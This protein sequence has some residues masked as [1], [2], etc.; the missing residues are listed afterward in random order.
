MPFYFGLIKGSKTLRN[1][2]TAATL[3]V[4]TDEENLAAPFAFSTK[5]LAISFPNGETLKFPDITVNFGEKILLSGD[6]GAGKSTL[7]KLLLGILLP[8]SGKI[9]FKDQE[10]KVI[11]PDLAKIGYIAQDP[12]LFPSTIKNNITMFDSKL[13]QLAE[14]AAV[15]VG[16]KPDLAQFAQGIET[17]L[18]LQKLNVS[19]GQRQKIIL[20]RTQIHDSK[21]LLIDEGTSAI[22]QEGTRVILQELLKMPSTVI[23]IAHNFDEKLQ[24]LFDREIHL[25]K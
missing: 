25:S 3:P 1:K 6:S 12:V 22:D 5:D 4:K 17:K 16:L 14:P 9:A 18:N 7:F 21:I 19:G 8:S 20:A 13:N 11:K 24:S 15:A 23:F 2:V 10:G